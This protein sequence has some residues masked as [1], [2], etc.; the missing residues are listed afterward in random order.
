VKSVVGAWRKKPVTIE[1]ARWLPDDLEV[2][3]QIAGW[4]QAHRVDFHVDGDYSL[5]LPTLEGTMQATPGDWIIRG[6][7]GEFYPCK[8][9]I[10]EAT[11][12][13]TDAGRDDLGGQP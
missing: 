9:A 11:Y 6:I 1:A 12:E 13:S 8:N 4:L 5:S 2:A 7:Q 3:G 10:F